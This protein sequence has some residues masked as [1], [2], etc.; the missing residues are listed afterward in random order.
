MNSFFDENGLLNLDEAVLKQASFQKIMAD[1]VVTDLELFQQGERVT[2][3]MRRLESECSP[4]QVELIKEL[5]AEMSVLYTVY[6]YSELQTI[7]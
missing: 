2:A 5:I 6:H 4:G 3:L 1:G 7:V